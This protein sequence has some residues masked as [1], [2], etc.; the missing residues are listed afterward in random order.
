MIYLDI[1]FVK[2]LYTKTE[3]SAMCKTS[4]LCYIT[5]FSLSCCFFNAL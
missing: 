3:E 2:A 5:L 4:E 1:Y